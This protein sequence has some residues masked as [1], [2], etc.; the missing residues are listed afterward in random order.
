MSKKTSVSIVRIEKDI[1]ETVRKAVDLVGGLAPRISQGD[2]VLIKPNFIREEPSHVGTTTNIEVIKAT[3]ALVKEAGGVPTVAE[4]SGNQYDTEYIYRTLGL[5]EALG[6]VT[7]MDLDQD[8]IVT[9]KN[10]DAIALKEVG[11]ARTVLEADLIIGLPLLKTH[12]TTSTTIGMKNMMGVL[13]QREKWKMHMSGLH[14]AL[15]DLN[16]I[17]KP[18]FV[19]VDGVVGMEGFGPTIGS[20]VEMNLILAGEDVVAVDTVGSYVMGFQPQE[21]KHLELAGE[22][23]LGIHDLNEI[24]IL[25][26]ELESVVRAFKRS[27]GSKVIEVWAANQ[28][29]LGTFL[30]NR[31]N[32]DIRG[33]L[34]SVS[35]IYVTKP[36]LTKNLC[37]ICGLCVET[38]PTGA[39]TI[40]S[41]PRFDYTRCTK[42]LRCVQHCP[43][44]AL[45]PSRKPA[46]IL[47]LFSA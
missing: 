23:G 1:N 10:D 31:F 14:Q 45:R 6:D 3:V 40:D 42:C 29:R 4:A 26:E 36:Q 24:E 9:I 5:R 46:T 13:P 33:F 18:G 39:V 28:Y 7:V 41:Y 2:K 37:D 22:Q 17:A 47:K 21:V 11:V 30:L 12:M 8:E 15:V 44:K 32:Y 43:V 35:D 27:F 25:G 19:I 20:P 16:R 34:K 38:C